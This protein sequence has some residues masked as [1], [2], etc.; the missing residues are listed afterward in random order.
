MTFQVKEPILVIG[1]G[2]AGSK[3]AI[4]AKDAL[5]SDCLL[6]S[7]DQKDL[8]SGCNSIK[9]STDSIIN[10]S[11]QLIRGATYKVV[12]QIKSKISNYSTIILMTNLA[13]KTGS[14]ISPVVSEICK[15]SDKGLVSFAIM[16]FKYEKDRIFNSGISLKRL[17]ANSECTIV[18][19]NDSLLE[20][21]PDLSPNTC[22]S[23]ANNAIMHVVSSLH[24][25]D[26]SNHTNILTTSKDGQS[27]E[28]SLRDSLKMLYENTSPN[29]VKRSMLYVVGGNN[30]P[31]GVINSITNLTN[32]ILS[33]SSSQ[34]DMI[35]SNESKIVMLSSIQGMTKFEKYDP[36]GVIPQENTLDWSQPDCSIDY[37]LDLY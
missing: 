35:S 9:V 3:L 15:E 19:D 23:I 29:A 11:V 31:V 24:T 10:P 18:L 12:D 7:N 14:A 33:E 13:G 8:Q 30:I 32:G 28:E 36:L 20:S 25:S 5:N 22:Y 16:P 17:T 34:V 1:L 26:I 4:Q 6:I 37:K 2:G 27:L 21:N